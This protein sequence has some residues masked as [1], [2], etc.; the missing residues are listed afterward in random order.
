MQQPATNKTH[1]D[2]GQHITHNCLSLNN[3]FFFLGNVLI[4]VGPTKEGIIIPLFQKRL[5]Q[6]GQ[7]LDI[8]GEAIYDTSPWIYQNDSLNPNV[9]YTCVKEPYHKFEPIAIPISSDTIKAV[10]AIFL[11]WPTDGILRIKDAQSALTDQN[12]MIQLIKPNGYVSVIVST[13]LM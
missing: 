3:I 4:N 13:H 12:Y 1:N 2:D 8:Y 5:L 6:L 10:Y 9:W 7:W 11:K